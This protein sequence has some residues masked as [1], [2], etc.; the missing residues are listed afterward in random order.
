MMFREMRRK[1]RELSLEEAQEIIKNGQYGVLAVIGENGYPYGVPLHY[2]VIDDKIYF[3]S[4]SDGG[5]KADSMK[6][7]PKISFTVIEPQEGLRSK[8]AI[9]FGTANLV[10][11]MREKV[12]EE[13]I[14]K[15]VP[16]VAWE[17]AKTGIPFAK[18]RIE[19]YELAIEQLT[20]KVIDK[21]E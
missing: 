2:V 1:D 3:H 21:P 15:F 6:L 12:L 13:M 19:A 20:A 18:D 5:H 14:E 7:N 9:I 17:Q 8:S 16:V 11:D 4:T 10:P